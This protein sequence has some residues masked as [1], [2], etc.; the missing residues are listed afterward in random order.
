MD[1]SFKD[2]DY[3]FQESVRDWLSVNWSDDLKE[4]QNKSA[5]KRLSKEDLV[6]WQKRLAEKGWAAPNW[7]KNMGAQALPL[8]RIIYSI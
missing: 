4:K 1:I 2:E 7:P 6:A 5:L 8:Y 3:K